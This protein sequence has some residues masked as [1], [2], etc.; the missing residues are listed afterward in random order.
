MTVRVTSIVVAKSLPV[1][2]TVFAGA[3]ADAGAMPA[4]G[5]KLV[6]VAVSTRIP[7]TATS[8]TLATRRSGRASVSS[9]RT[10]RVLL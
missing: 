3:P 8:S 9:R 2:T 1:I 6:S 10:L 7:A 4:G 5:A